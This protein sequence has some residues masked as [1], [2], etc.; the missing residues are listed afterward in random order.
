MEG[1]QTRR[2]RPACA[3]SGHAAAPPSPAMNSRRF[4]AIPPE[5]M[6]WAST[7]AAQPSAPALVLPEPL[8]PVWCKGRVSLRAPD[9]AVA[10][11]ALDCPRVDERSL[12]TSDETRK[13]IQS[14]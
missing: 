7:F 8:E 14:T 11:V 12:P 2:G 6:R 4:M 1:T 3:V 10:E 13:G 5:T 9:R